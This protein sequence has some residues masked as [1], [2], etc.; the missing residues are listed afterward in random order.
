MH[1]RKRPPLALGEGRG[2]GIR[3]GSKSRPRT[4]KIRQWRAEVER[5]GLGLRSE[6][7][8]RLYASR[9]EEKSVRDFSGE[10][11]RGG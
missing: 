11:E 1:T 10:R 7:N 2:E 3:I 9:G 8:R 6:K 4:S 5:V